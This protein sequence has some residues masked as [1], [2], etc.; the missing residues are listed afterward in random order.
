MTSLV[1]VVIGEH[2]SLFG[3][4]DE[5][6]NRKTLSQDV[7]KMNDRMGNHFTGL[8]FI[9]NVSKEARGFD[10]DGDNAFSLYCESSGLTSC[11]NWTNAERPK[12]KEDDWDAV[13]PTAVSLFE[14]MQNLTSDL[15]HKLCKKEEDAILA[16]KMKEFLGISKIDSANKKLDDVME[17]EGGS[18]ETLNSMMGKEVDKN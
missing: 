16:G 8:P 6:G 4:G 11:E 18:N 12:I 17:V 15:W 1:T 14:I 2:F 9:K 7:I 13:A 10:K 3:T 5:L